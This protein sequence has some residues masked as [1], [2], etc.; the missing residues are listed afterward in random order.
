LVSK[1]IEIQI[2]KI[3]LC[4]FKSGYY[5]YVG[6]AIYAQNR[7]QEIIHSKTNRPD[8]LLKRVL[9]HAKPMIDKRRHWH[10]DYLLENEGVI[11]ERIICI[12]SIIREECLIAQQIRELAQDQILG[13]GCSDCECPSHLFYFGTIFPF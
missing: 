6:S 9:R 5:S 2:G 10:I 8:L 13:F 1:S 4:S 3:G 12:P 7:L 11:L